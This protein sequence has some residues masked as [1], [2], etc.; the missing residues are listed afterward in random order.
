MGYLTCHSV[1]ANMGGGGVTVVFFFFFFYGRVDTSL[2]WN[3]FLSFRLPLSL[4]KSAGFC[5]G[6]FF[7]IM[8]AI[9]GQLHQLQIW[10]I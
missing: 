9:S 6:S 10:D 2:S 3:F 7:P 4:A 8:V 5:C 1:F